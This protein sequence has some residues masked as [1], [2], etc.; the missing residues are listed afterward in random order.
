MRRGTRLAPHASGRAKFRAGKLEGPGKWEP[1]NAGIRQFWGLFPEGDRGLTEGGP[2]GGQRA[3][4][5]S[6]PDLRGCR[7]PVPLCPPTASVPKSPSKRK[8]SRATR[9]HGRAPLLSREVELLRSVCGIPGL[10]LLER[11]RAPRGGGRL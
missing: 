2:A 5:D 7:F 3:L 10:Q 1:G 11:G 9:G 4:R 6:G 8:L